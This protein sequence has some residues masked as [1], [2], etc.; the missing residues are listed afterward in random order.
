MK[1]KKTP[2][3]DGIPSNVLK[4]VCKYK[5]NLLFSA[6]NICLQRVFP[7]GW[8]T[9]RLVLMSKGRGDSEAASAYCPLRILDTAGKLLEKLIKPELTDTICAGETAHKHKSKRSTIDPFEETT[10][11][12]TEAHSRHYRRVVLLVTLDVKNAS[13]SVKGCHMLEVLA[14]YFLI[15]GNLLRTLIDYL[16]NRALLY[17]TRK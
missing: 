3:P 1:S 15:P 11:K 9:A 8:N 12:L 7:S 6:F 10:V 5:Q 13:Y 16:K 14:N 2:R 17:E 4:L